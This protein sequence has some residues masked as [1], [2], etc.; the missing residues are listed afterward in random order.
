MAEIFTYRLIINGINI[1]TLTFA[2]NE[3]KVI[4]MGENYHRSVYKL[5]SS[6]KGQKGTTQTAECGSSKG[7]RVKNGGS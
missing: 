5:N 4:C 6:K 2:G 3:L 7:R 1:N